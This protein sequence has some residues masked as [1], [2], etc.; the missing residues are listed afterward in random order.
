MDTP[1]RKG[2]ICCV[3][4]C[5]NR[6]NGHKWPKDTT[7]SRKWFAAVR[8][9]GDFNPTKNESQRRNSLVCKD[10]FRPEDYTLLRYH[11]MLKYFL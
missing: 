9:A 4:G 1:T 7:L 8:R 3:P 5:S 11:G 10:H 2:R 6:G